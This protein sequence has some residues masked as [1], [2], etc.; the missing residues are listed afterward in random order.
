MSIIG[1]GRIGRALA[2]ALRERGVRVSGPT[3]RGEEI[4]RAD[5]ALLCVPDRDIP[6]AAG[7]AT[8]RADL[9]GH[10]SG[11]T[12]VVGVDFGIHPLQTFT[13]SEGAE[14][15]RE[16]ACGIAGTSPRAE[17]AAE[18]LARLLGARPFPL[19]N[20]QRAAYH[21]AASIASGAVVAVCDAAERVAGTA[22]FTPEQTREMFAPLARRALENWIAFGSSAL[23][24]P[25][26]RG[27]QHT[28]DRQRAAVA[29]TTEETRALFHA[30]V[31][32][33]TAM[34]R[35]EPA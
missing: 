35:E 2:R 28:V 9:I 23:T 17:Q 1:A 16:V 13:G 26:A 5:L 18:R 7:A 14:A 10:V 15:F 29:N 22:G 33:M 27:D 30:L 6:A 21:A 24:G 3:G 8:G 25:V 4:A 32:Y 12:P 31:A 11:A 34:T 19:S 20:E